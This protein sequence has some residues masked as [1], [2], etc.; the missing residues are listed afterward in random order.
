MKISQNERGLLLKAPF[1]TNFS[2]KEGNILAAG[3]KY[4][5]FWNRIKSADLG[6]TLSDNKYSINYLHLTTEIEEMQ[7]ESVSSDSNLLDA[8]SPRVI[9]IVPVNGCEKDVFDFCG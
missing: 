1:R 7:F 2:L 6:N 8:F 3:R 9:E 5:G 4:P